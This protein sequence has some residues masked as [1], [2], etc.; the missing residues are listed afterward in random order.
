MAGFMDRAVSALRGVVG[1]E[2]TEFQA[3]GPGTVGPTVE[4][5]GGELVT[6]P[7]TPEFIG[8]MW[9]EVDKAIQR[10]K[11]REEQ[12][13][14][15]LKAYLPAVHQGAED[16]KTNAHFRNVHTKLG[17]LFYRSPD[18]IMTPKDPSPAQNQIPNPNFDPMN[19][20]AGPPF[21]TMED[22]IA[23]KQA[24]LQQKL[25]R[26]GV[27]AERLVDELL[28]DVLTWAGMGACKIGYRCVTKPIERPVM[29]P[30]PQPPGA[31]LGLSAQQMP[32]VPQIGPDGNPLMETIPVPV[33]EEWYMRRFSP[34]KLLMDSSLRS[35]RF[36]EDATLM[37]MIFF[38]TPEKAAKAFN[39]PV[40]EMA[41]GTEDDRAYQYDQDSKAKPSGLVMGVELW[42]KASYWTDEVNPEIINQLVLIQGIHDKPAVWR[43]SPD[44]SIDPET[45]RLT[46][47]SLLG[48][49]IEVLTIR[50]SPDS[51]FVHSDAAFT[52]P[53]VKELNT[54]R[55][56]QVK[57]RDA[58][59]GKMLVDGAYFEEPELLKLRNGE[60]G[61]SILVKENAL[62]ELGAKGLI[63]TTAQVRSTADDYRGQDIIKQDMDETLGISG[64]QAGT[65]TSTVR[66]ATE[67]ATFSS[68]A[69]ARNEKERGRVVDFYLR[70][71][72]KLDTLLMRYADQTQYIQITGQEGAARMMMWNQQ[73][74][75]GRYLYDIAPDSQM[76]PDTAVDFEQELR[77]YNLAAPDPLFNRAY[78]LRKLARM[79]GYDPQKVVLNPAQQLTQPSHGGQAAE[80][81]AV[82]K[83]QQ[84]ISGGRENAPGATNQQDDTTQ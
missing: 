1:Q 28:M 63:D 64:P 69:Q 82:S 61:E 50:D 65:P 68:G 31:V 49:P 71:A 62:K 27:N 78:V 54:W 20:A 7:F 81:T 14:I 32:P 26:D 29:G 39:I 52:N 25:G 57:L 23:V 24:V 55:R 3:P 48:F 13:K 8:Q 41:K 11:D 53:Q 38:M 34:M 21:L 33:F 44:Q 15:L 79:R 83:H 19:P 66:S 2:S 46:Q 58:A 47:D 35:V 42:L 74:I 22:I 16:L 4:T 72:R 80:G 60:V 43:M 75:S 18:L 40:S 70:A 73:I 59:I 76:A 51:S 56:Q 36:D 84:A 6:L 77:F 12:W 67:V 45:G 10:V 30:P 17:Q 37:G 9:K 5:K